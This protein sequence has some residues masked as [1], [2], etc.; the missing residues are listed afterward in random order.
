LLVGTEGAGLTTAVESAADYRVR[1]PISGDV[2]SLN[3]ASATAI[4]LYEF[5]R[6]P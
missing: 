4:A 1:I 6:R 2:D 5:A 3:V